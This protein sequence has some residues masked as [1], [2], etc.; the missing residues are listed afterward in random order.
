M[1]RLCAQVA[2]SAKSWFVPRCGSTR[3]KSMPQYP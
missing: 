1:P 2:K 3:V